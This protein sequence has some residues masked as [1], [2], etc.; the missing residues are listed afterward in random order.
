MNTQKSF[1]KWFCI[2]MC[3]ELCNRSF[4]IDRSIKSSS[5]YGKVVGQFI[6]M[7]SKAN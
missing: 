1:F 2:S 7:L 5:N 6:I 4:P 3:C